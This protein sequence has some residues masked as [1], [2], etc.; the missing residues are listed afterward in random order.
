MSTAA[1]QNMAM[2]KVVKYHGILKVSSLT[3][4][5]YIAE[6]L[7]RGSL[8]VLSI[9]LLTELYTASYNHQQITE[10]NGFT[11]PMVVWSLVL[12][13]SFYQAFRPTVAKNIGNEIVSGSIVYALNRP[14]S[15]PLY[16]YFTQVGRAVPSLMLNLVVCSIAALI[17]VGPIPFHLSAVLL[18]FMLLIFGYTIEFMITFSIGLISFWVEDVKPFVWIYS[19]MQWTLGGFFVPLTLYPDGLRQVA[20]LLPF[21]NTFYAPARLIVNF[22]LSLFFQLLL[23]QLCWLTV[24]FF[25]TNLIFKKAVKYVAINGG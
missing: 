24:L 19:K 25:F 7:S 9:W 10:I 12:V 21:S 22:E 15:Y 4:T 11:L 1:F 2:R 3:K 18:G 13:H 16:H 6:F 23:T 17:L 14:Y 20:S 5:T 8:V